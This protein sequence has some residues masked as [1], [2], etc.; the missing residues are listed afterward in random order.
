M[1]PRRGRAARQGRLRQARGSKLAVPVS[2]L[3]ARKACGSLCRL[4]RGG[5]GCREENLAFDT[6]IASG[7]SASSEQCWHWWMGG[8]EGP[9]REQGPAPSKQRRFPSSRPRKGFRDSARRTEIRV[10]DAQIG[11]VQTIPPRHRHACRPSLERRNARRPAASKAREGGGQCAGHGK[12]QA[13]KAPPTA[14]GAGCASSLRQLGP[15]GPPPPARQR[16]RQ[17]CLRWNRGRQWSMG[18]M[19]KAGAGAGMTNQGSRRG[20]IGPLLAWG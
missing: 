4:R 17:L 15:D 8:A 2:A 7:N 3:A 18:A 19:Q 11:G 10:W 13:G 14:G 1:L 5:A 9:D 20:G 12:H 16:Q 6:E